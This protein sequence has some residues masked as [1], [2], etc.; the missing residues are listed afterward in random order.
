MARVVHWDEHV[1]LRSS[2]AAQICRRRVLE[3]VWEERWFFLEGNSFHL[4]LCCWFRGASRRQRTGRRLPTL[5]ESGFNLAKKVEWLEE[6]LKNDAAGSPQLA[7]KFS[8]MARH[9]R[10]NVNVAQLESQR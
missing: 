4:F 2:R 9:P 3:S 1:S 10:P 7:F 6:V 5:R 8:D